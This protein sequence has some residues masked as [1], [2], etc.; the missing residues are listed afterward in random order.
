MTLPPTRSRP[1]GAPEPDHDRT[2][3]SL[4]GLGI[5]FAGGIVLFVLLGNWADKRFGLRPWGVLAG[6]AIGFG[7]GLYMLVRAAKRAE[8]EPRGTSDGPGAKGNGQRG[9]SA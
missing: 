6:L 1:G 7:G 9:G 4:A 3:S 2:G 5:Q 8:R